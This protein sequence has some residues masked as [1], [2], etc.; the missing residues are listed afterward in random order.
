MGISDFLV[1]I[2][3]EVRASG[4]NPRSAPWKV[5]IS[6]PSRRGFRRVVAL[7]GRAI[8]TSG[9]YENYF[10]WQGRAYSHTVDPASGWPIGPETV[11]VSVIAA[12]CMEADA[13]ATACDVLGAE[14]SLALAE[15][16]GLAI[17]L[18]LRSQKAGGYSDRV[19]DLFKGFFPK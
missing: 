16:E 1:E 17:Y 6:D 2:G 18:V 14:K 4:S 10:E 7:S 13:W 11:S 15:R 9:S 12:T 19:S 3:G 5:A 8:A